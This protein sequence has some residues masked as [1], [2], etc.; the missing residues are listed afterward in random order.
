M[1]K[2]C[3]SGESETDDDEPMVRRTKMFT[4]SEIAVLVKYC[5]KVIAGGVVNETRV[6]SALGSS[7]LMKD[8][9]FPQLRTR[10][11][12]ERKK[13]QDRGVGNMLET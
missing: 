7:S 1:V 6:R 3:T 4:P 5:G 10:I 12:F 9:T 11:M 2:D 8:Y 13:R